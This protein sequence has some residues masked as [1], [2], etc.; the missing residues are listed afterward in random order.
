MVVLLIVLLGISLIV[1]IIAYRQH[2]VSN[3]QLQYMNLKLQQILR[4]KTNE[5]VFIHTDNAHLQLLLVQLNE[6]LDHNQ[7]MA[8]EYVRIERSMRRMLSNISHDIKTPLTVIVGYTEMLAHDKEL[9]PEQLRA[10]LNIINV[11]A[12]EVIE[13]IHTFFELSKLESADK[14]IE[15]S[16]IHINEVCRKKIVEYYDM[17]TSQDI[18]VSIRIPED[19]YAAMASTIELERVLDNLIS[20]AIKYGADGHMLEMVVRADSE[21]VYIEVTDQGKGIN[22]EQQ[23]YVFERMYT[24]DDARNRENKS[25]GLGLTISKTLVEK[26]GGKLS[27]KSKPFE[28]T[29]FTIQLNR[30][31]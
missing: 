18:E 6:L 24:L 27:L 4:K 15:C 19:T 23:E 29:T 26:M 9:D 16:S 31:R 2:N 14:Q 10:F 13:L 1:H 11:K 20:N 3:K 8:A 25:S 17:I 12:E 30:K 5:K 7:K 28:R 21:F 22:E